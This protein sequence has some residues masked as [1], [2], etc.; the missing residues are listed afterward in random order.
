MIMGRDLLPRHTGRP[1]WRTALLCGALF[2]SV[3]CGTTQK[4]RVGVIAPGPAGNSSPGGAPAGPGRLLHLAPGDA[5]TAQ[6]RIIHGLFGEIGSLS[7][8]VR[9]DPSPGS[10]L[11]RGQASGSGAVLGFGA[12]RQTVDSELDAAAGRTVRYS[13]YRHLPDR[14]FTDVAVQATPGLVEI[15]R[16]RSGRPD[17]RSVF[18]GPAPVL[19]PLGFLLR[20]RATGSNGSAFAPTPGKQQTFALLDGQ[21]H[22]QVTVTARAN[23]ES[24]SIGGQTY[25]TRVFDAVSHAYTWGH[26]PM[27]G[28]EP[29]RLTLWITDDDRRLPVLLTADSPLGNV[30]VELATVKIAAVPVAL[31]RR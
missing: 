5:E 14:E 4:P 16:K 10:G 19:D 13:S 15:V 20:L 8:V 26:K 27:P 3:A 9:N 18:H 23:R 1:A 7:I 25:R 29:R 17:E 11:L 30:R 12:R 24:V 2:G 22:S 28:R 31:A 6:Y 21:A